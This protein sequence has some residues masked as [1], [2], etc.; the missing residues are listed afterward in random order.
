VTGGNGTPVVL[1]VDDEPAI[2][3]LCRVHL[4]LDGYRVLEAT[5]LGEA[6]RLLE[7]EEIAVALLDMR[8]GA[9][10]GTGLLDDLEAHAVPVVVVT[11][12]AEVEPTWAHRAAAVLGKPFQIDELLRHVRALAPR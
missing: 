6:R 9:E 11:G 2:R 12:S 8:I 10:R 5:S 7:A 1:V 3:L 4:E